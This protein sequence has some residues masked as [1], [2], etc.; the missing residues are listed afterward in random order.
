MR[1]LLL[2]ALLVLSLGNHQPLTD[3]FEAEFDM[4]SSRYKPGRINI[5]ST[6]RWLDHSPDH[7][8]LSSSRYLTLHQQ[9]K[10]LQQLA[11]LAPE[12]ME[13]EVDRRI[14]IIMALR[15]LVIQE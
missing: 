3:Y 4:A 15:W 6:T 5:L 7:L 8:Q 14:Y 9:Y 10:F 12:S 2:A 11:R 13:L 1:V